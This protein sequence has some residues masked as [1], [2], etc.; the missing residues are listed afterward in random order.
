MSYL[1]KEELLSKL[2][3]ET[4][5]SIGQSI[6]SALGPFG[7]G[8]LVGAGVTLLLAPKS[9][10]DLRHDIRHKL[11]REC[12]TGRA[13]ANIRHEDAESQHGA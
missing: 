7:I 4:K 12:V 10:R 3:L 2:G 9:G 8:L 6:L 11:S 1:N 5:A 13:E